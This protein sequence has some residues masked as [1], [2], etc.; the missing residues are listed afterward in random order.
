MTAQARPTQPEQWIAQ[1]FS[2]RVADG[3]VVRRRATWVQ[4]EIGEDRLAHE[5]RR[6]GFHMVRSGDQYVIFCNAAGLQIIC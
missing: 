5:V 4:R 3:G 6:R 2:A 1:I